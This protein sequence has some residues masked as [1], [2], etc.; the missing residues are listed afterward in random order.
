MTAP[1]T[2]RKQWPP[3]VAAGRA[4][5]NSGF[6]RYVNHCGRLRSVCGGLWRSRKLQFWL[7]RTETLPRLMRCHDSVG[8]RR[9]AI[10]AYW[11]HSRQEY[12]FWRNH[13]CR[14]RQRES[15]FPNFVSTLWLD[16]VVTSSC[17]GTKPYHH[18]TGADIP[19][20][21]RPV[22]DAYVS[23]SGQVRGQIVHSVPWHRG[24]IER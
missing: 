24:D 19:E 15:E 1:T 9:M 6:C 13:R 18:G 3:S 5:T 23:N 10:P 14:G 4:V 7:W 21:Q 16:G 17:I 20:A 2:R 8:Q 12:P 22:E 11:Q